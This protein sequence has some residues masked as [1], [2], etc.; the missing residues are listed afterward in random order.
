MLS[1][2][3]FDDR[4]RK[5]S[6]TGATRRDRTGDLLITN[7]RAYAFWTALEL[8]TKS[9]PK[10]DCRPTPLK[11]A[12]MRTK[13]RTIAVRIYQQPQLFHTFDPRDPICHRR[14]VFKFGAGPLERGYGDITPEV[15]AAVAG[16]AEDR[17][18]GSRRLFW[19]PPFREEPKPA[20]P[21]LVLARG[22]APLVPLKLAKRS[23]VSIGRQTHAHH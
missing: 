1:L 11:Y 21:T 14:G 8:K 2:L 19:R 20:G 4:F 5:L 7:Q 10:T 15:H 17:G 23:P 3:F 13:M 16:V 18:S 9:F 12:Q 6:G 22:R